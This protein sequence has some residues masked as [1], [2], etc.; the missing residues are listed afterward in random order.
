MICERRASAEE[1]KSKIKLDAPTGGGLSL[2]SECHN[3]S[4]LD[5]DVE[6]PF[7]NKH[8][9]PWKRKEKMSFGK[10]LYK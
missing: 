7:A 10:T 5:I 6:N 9:F 4:R 3:P 1:G 2:Q 8:N